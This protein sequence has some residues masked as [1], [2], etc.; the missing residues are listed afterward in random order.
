MT[1]FSPAMPIEAGTIHEFKIDKDRR[2]GCTLPSDKYKVTK[3]DN[4]DGIYN[5]YA[6]TG[7]K[8]TVDDEDEDFGGDD[9]CRLMP[10]K[11]NSCP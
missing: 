10:C 7:D 11:I 2:K 3:V 4:E 6:I 9:I 1:H 5:F 8:F